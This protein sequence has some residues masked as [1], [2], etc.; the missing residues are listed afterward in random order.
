MI[1]QH[2]RTTCDRTGEILQITFNLSSRL[3]ILCAAVILVNP[4]AKFAITMEPVALGA[5]HAASEALKMQ[6]TYWFRYGTQ[7][8]FVNV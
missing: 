6:K 4:I 2:W 8:P 3:K 7:G 5:R 1:L